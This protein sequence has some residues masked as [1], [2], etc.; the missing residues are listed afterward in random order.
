MSSSTGKHCASTATATTPTALG[1]IHHSSPV[2]AT[3]ANLCCTVVEP[4]NITVQSSESDI[5]REIEELE[6]LFLNI[7][8]EAAEDL[9]TVKLSKIKLCVTQLPVSVKYQHLHFLDHNRSALL[10]LRVLTISSLFWACTGAISI[11]G[12]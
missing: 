6:S 9:T 4:S 1:D 10:V 5:D 2:T 7:V 12:S 8:S 3:E 11:A